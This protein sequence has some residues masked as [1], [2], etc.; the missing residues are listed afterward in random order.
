MDNTPQNYGK[1]ICKGLQDLRIEE[2]HI[3]NVNINYINS[4]FECIIDSNSIKNG[5]HVFYIY[6]HTEYFSTESRE[7]ILFVNN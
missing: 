6:F 1:F 7:L 2:H 4:G 3:N 5:V